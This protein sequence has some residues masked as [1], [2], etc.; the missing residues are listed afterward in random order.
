MNAGEFQGVIPVEY[1]PQGAHTLKSASTASDLSP[2]AF[3]CLFFLPETA[4]EIEIEN[5]FES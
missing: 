4:V 1:N 3:F 5:L 2:V